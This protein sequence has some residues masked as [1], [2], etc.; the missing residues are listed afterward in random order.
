MDNQKDQSGTTPDQTNAGRT[1]SAN[2]SIPAS[3]ASGAS[4]VS[5][6]PMPGASDAV[7]IPASQSS[8]STA[9]GQTTT[10]L[11]T[12]LNSGKKW[13]EDSEV[14]NGVN[15][16]PESLKGLGNRAVDRINSLSTTQKVVGS[17][18]LAAGLGWLA[19]RKGK[20]SSS[21]SSASNYGRQRDAGSYGR[22]SYG[23][24]A[25]VASTSHHPLEGTSG[26]ADSGSPYG[27]SGSRF[28]SSANYN[29]DPAGNTRAQSGSR[30]DDSGAGPGGA[31]AGTD[32]GRQ[33][34]GT[35]YRSTE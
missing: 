29:P 19:T 16:L 15:Q 2:S 7:P 33:A 13:V 27:N 20:S 4:T 28:G 22:K 8:A 18:I 31:S 26:R 1:T 9:N 25:P 30:H 24:Q 5:H 11:D 14:F 35:D 12:A 34:A 17:A 23:Y 3:A 6:K 32:H 10:L 21:D